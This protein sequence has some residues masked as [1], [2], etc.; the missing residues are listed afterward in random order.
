[1]VERRDTYGPLEIDRVTSG[2]SRC[3]FTAQKAELIALTRA[4]YLDKGQRVTI[5]TDSEC[6]FLILHAHAAIWREQGHLPSKN[7]PIQ[8][9]LAF[10]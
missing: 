7:S 5:Y 4:L 8:A 10:Y 9:I 2:H 6:A 1:M 3:Q